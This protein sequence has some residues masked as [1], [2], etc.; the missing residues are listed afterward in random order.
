VQIATTF[1]KIIPLVAVVL[2]ALFVFGSGE[3][4]AATAA[5]N[6]APTPIGLGAIAGAAAL[7]LWPMQGFESG[8]V[9]A[10]RVIDPARTIARATLIG[11]LLVGMLYVLV[12]LAV[13]LLL[14]SE[15]ASKSSAPLADLM[16]RVMGSAAGKLVAAF[17]AI[18][19]I[20]ALNGWVLLQA[21]VQLLLAERGVF[22]KFFTRVNKNG[23]PVYAQLLGCTLSVALIA[24]NLSGG[25][26]EIYSFIV[27]LAT[28]ATLVL[29]LAGALTMLALIKRGQAKGAIVTGCALIGGAYALWTF[30]GAGGEATAWGAALLATGIPV[31]FLMRRSSPSVSESLRM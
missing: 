11:T 21:E 24:T 12:T 27:L 15:V 23:M 26:I 3:G 28:V 8:T 4:T 1:L 16:S 31:Y 9:P 19:A 2:L 17:A 18:S 10:G 13:L 6:V 25:M 7:A 14:P 20:G 30:Y 29:Y 22:P 5:A